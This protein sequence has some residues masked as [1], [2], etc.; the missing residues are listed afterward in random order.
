MLLAL[1]PLSQDED[2]KKSIVSLT[3][4]VLGQ[5]ALID[6]WGPVFSILD[7]CKNNNFALFSRYVTWLIDCCS[8]KATQMHLTALR[9]PTIFFNLFKQVFLFVFLYNCIF[10]FVDL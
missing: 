1:A 10:V 2:I 3:G 5:C 7:V 8:K 4:L 9:K 6:E